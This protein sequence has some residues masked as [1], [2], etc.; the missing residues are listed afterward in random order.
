MARKGSLTIFRTVNGDID[1][2]YMGSAGVGGGVNSKAGDI[3]DWIRTVYRESRG[4]ELPGT[5]NP[6]LLEALFRQQS[7][8]WKDLSEKYISEVIQRASVYNGGALKDFV[9]DKEVRRKIQDLFETQLQATRE[10]A[11][12]EPHA[13]LN[14]ELGGILQ[15]ANHYF[16]DTLSQIREERAMARL[17]HMGLHDG[18][19]I[20]VNLRAMVRRGHTSNKDQAVHDIHASSRHTTRSLSSG[21][22]TM[23]SSRWWRDISWA[24][25]A[26]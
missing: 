16:A 17:R 3:Y 11:H 4:T 21:L 13:L 6:R 15:T 5:V 8:S 18:Q 7:S 25:R 10:R 14:S 19:H 23:S 2:P 26:R 24:R 22:R 9:S 1:W 12:A 20:T